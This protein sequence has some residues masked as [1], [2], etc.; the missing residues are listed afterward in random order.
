MNKPPHRHNWS[1]GP[2]PSPLLRFEP[3]WG[4]SA[5]VAERTLSAR[6]DLRRGADGGRSETGPSAISSHAGAACGA[7]VGDG[8]TPSPA[9][10]SAGFGSDLIADPACASHG[11]ALHPASTPSG[12]ASCVSPAGGKPA[13]ARSSASSSAARS[14]SSASNASRG[15]GATGTART[16]A[17]FMPCRRSC[18]RL[19]RD[20]YPV[21]PAP[22]ALGPGHSYDQCALELHFWHW[23]G[24]PVP[25]TPRGFE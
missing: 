17:V 23:R 22:A 7:A 9:S 25:V 3:P 15:V 19:G 4:D 24:P 5:C 13:S 11:P 12:A 16:G 2:S 14:F 21:L 8:A 1:S 6:C 18:V 20:T 10:S